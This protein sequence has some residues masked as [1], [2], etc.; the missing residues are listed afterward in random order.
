[1]VCG[2]VAVSV[3]DK[4][5]TDLADNAGSAGNDSV[6]VDTKAP[7]V[8]VTINNDGTVSFAFSEAVKNFDADDV[9]GPQLPRARDPVH[10][11]VV[12][13]N[14]A[15]R[16]ERHLSR[17][18][19]EQRDRSV[20]HEERLDRRVDLARRHAGPNHLPGNLMGTPDHEPCATHEGDFTGRA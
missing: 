8:N 20:A 13:G 3:A 19:L 5:Y 4:S 1:M 17:N 11:L 2:E 12:D 10:D 18:P 15:H 7:T 6:T 9:T 16:R 14:A